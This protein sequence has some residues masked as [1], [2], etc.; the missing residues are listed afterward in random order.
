MDPITKEVLLE[1][2]RQNPGK[3]ISMTHQ[4]LDGDEGKPCGFVPNEP[5]GGAVQVVGKWWVTDR[6]K[7]KWVKKNLKRST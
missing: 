3:S 2:S 7:I 5:D 6:E 1:L 4:F